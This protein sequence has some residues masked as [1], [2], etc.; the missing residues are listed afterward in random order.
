MIEAAA[1]RPGLPR[2]SV[3]IPTYNRAADLKRCLESLCAQTFREFEVLVC[4]D[5]S[6]DNSASIVEQFNAR[7]D[8]SYHWRQNFGGPARPRNLGLSLARGPYVAFLDS[9]DW[10]APTKLE[11]S[12]SRLDAGADFVFHDLWIV[13]SAGQT[14][15]RHRAQTRPLQAPAYED[16]LTNGNAI[17]NSSAVVRRE[18]MLAIKGFSEDPA[19][20]AWEDYDAWLRV[21]KL[22]ERFERLKDPLGYYWVGGSNISSPKRLVANLDRFKQMYGSL[23][24]DTPEAL[25]PS[26]YHYNLGVAHYQLGNYSKAG[27]HLQ[28][29][30]R[31]RLSFLRRSKALYLALLSSLRPVP[32]AG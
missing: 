15:F 32:S 2:V 3:V 13:R 17:C 8:V 16:L 27:P 26:W 20:V 25:L 24:G 11:R 18:L 9:D 30:I 22:T 4:D 14:S 21:A 23:G 1:V 28:R 5:G 31:G 29:A 10:W 7:L 6:T 19:L 12:V